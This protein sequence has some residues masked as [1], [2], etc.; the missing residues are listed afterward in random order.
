MKV[1]YHGGVQYKR[2]YSITSPYLNVILI[3]KYNNLYNINYINK[4][5]FSYIYLLVELFTD[6]KFI[7]YLKSTI[8]YIWSLLLSSAI[9]S[10]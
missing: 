2:L 3:I 9:F 6:K 1:I 10:F 8:L 5:Y 4:I 7:K